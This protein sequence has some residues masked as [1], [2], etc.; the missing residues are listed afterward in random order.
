MDRSRYVSYRL[1]VAF[2]LGTVFFGVLPVFAPPVVLQYGQVPFLLL[3]L[4]ACAVVGA[5]LV[6]IVGGTA[7]LGSIVVGASALTGTVLHTFLYAIPAYGLSEA[8]VWAWFFVVIL[9]LVYLGLPALAG[10]A[11][12][13]PAFALVS[14]TGGRREEER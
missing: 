14:R 10:A 3:G 11:L 13:G 5:T 9:L 1:V 6:L 7:R 12:A 8:P 2:V 4:C